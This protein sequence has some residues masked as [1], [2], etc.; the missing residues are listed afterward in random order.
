[1]QLQKPQY[2]S[3]SDEGLMR[4]ISN[5]DKRA[6][7]ELYARYS[8]PLL[9]YFMRML[10]RDREKSEDFVHDLFAKIIRKPDYFDMERSFKTW[11]YSVANNMCKN[12]YKKQEVRKGMSNGLDNHYTLFDDS[13]NVIGEVQD[14]FF[15]EAFEE[16]MKKLDDKHREAFALRHIEGLSI[17]EIAEVLEINEG[18]IKSRLFYATKY[19]AEH[20]KIFNPIDNR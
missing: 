10:W 1:M 15:K 14:A 3:M 20:L 2:K 12:E 8:G 17:K 5:G 13:V 7:D 11:V 16:S 19:L 6:F 18:T 9:G 4:S